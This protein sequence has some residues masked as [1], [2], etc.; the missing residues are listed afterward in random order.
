ML[1]ASIRADKIPAD[2]VQHMPV[3]VSTITHRAVLIIATILSFNLVAPA[4]ASETVDPLFTG[5]APLE[6]TLTAPLRKMSRDKDEE[7][8]Y[9]DGTLAYIDAS[10]EERVL[11]L[12]VRPRGKSRRDRRVCAFPPLRLNFETKQLDDTVF[13]NQN[14]LKLV[15]HCKS[16]PAFQRYVLKE[17][18][19]Y[20]IFNLLSDASF[21][22]R[23]LKVTYVDSERNAKPVERY[24]FLIEHK[25][26][27][28]A[29]LGTEAVE[30]VR[31]RASELE[32]AQA[33]IAELYQYLVSNTDYSFIAA[34]PGDTCCHNAILLR[35]PDESYLPV[36]YDLDRTGIVDPPNAL[37]DE[38][39]GQRTVRDRLYRGFCRD[40]QYLSDAIAKTVEVRPQIEALFD[41]QPDLTPGDR[42]K[43]ASYLASFYRTVE[44]P[45]SRE[46]RL[47]CRGKR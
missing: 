5:D 35:G 18:L 2:G 44:D 37:P 41:E 40:S 4:F 21:K 14:V 27:L 16:S 1:H 23:L 13:A 9:S 43:A 38:N 22:V 10:G 24:G 30:P 15:T 31:I 28:A 36:P 8:E 17:Y 42:K 39:L 33:S 7:P 34:P 19:A 29:R 20:R 47:K 6:V 11:D 46:R 3:H 45:E 32:P 26:R 25:K 12:Q